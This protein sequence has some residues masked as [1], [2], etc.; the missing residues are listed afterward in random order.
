MNVAQLLAALLH[1]FEACRLAA[2]LD[3][4]RVWTIGWGHTA[5]VKEGD[6]CTAAQA[7]AWLAEDGQ[8]LLDLVK[9]E[10]LVA[11]AAW[12]SFGYNEGYHTLKDA[13]AGKFDIR[14]RVHDHLGH[15]LAGLVK[16]RAL[17]WALIESVSMKSA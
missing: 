7:D 6:T 16:R 17:E 1:L 3:T 4:G 13:L 5:G 8:P 2:Y 10:P 11:A 9:T 15:E 14:T 12:A